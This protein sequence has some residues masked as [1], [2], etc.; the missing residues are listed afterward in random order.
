MH[1]HH[2]KKVPGS[3]IVN[4]AIVGSNQRCVVVHAT[5]RLKIEDNVSFD[6][7][8]HCYMLEIGVEVDN[9]FRHNLGAATGRPNRIL[10]QQTD[11]LP[12]TFW[13]THPTNSWYDNV[14]AGSIGSG[15]WFE[16]TLSGG[17][18]GGFS[19]SM[20]N[21]LPI[22][23]FKDN[24]AHSNADKGFRTYPL[25]YFPKQQQLIEGLK[26]YRNEGSGIFLHNTRNL[27]I[28]NALVAD[29]KH[30]GIDIERAGGITI[31]GSTIIG[32]SDSFQAMD[33]GSNPCVGR[34]AYGIDLHSW[35]PDF[36]DGGVVLANNKFEGF[37]GIGCPQAAAI[38][39]DRNVSICVVP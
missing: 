24:V 34:I 37:Y 21:S 28:K 6:T 30:I 10:A 4:N 36:S 14:A 22:I 17:Q 27:R 12:S 3:R 5:D 20:P 23:A 16:T 19:Y 29:N 39:F 11:F 15:Y 2:C 13:I 38:H 8:G 33:D 9:V 32:Y 25:G 26:S 18:S 35:M 1:F 31:V 7:L